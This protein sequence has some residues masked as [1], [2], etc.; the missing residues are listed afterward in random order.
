[1]TSTHDDE[2]TDRRRGGLTMRDIAALAG[3]SSKSV[4]LVVNG[5]PGV[6]EQT[7][8]RIQELI[9]QHGYTPRAQAQ[10]LAT[11][12]AFLIA[13]VFNN[14]NPEY[15]MLMQ[16]GLLDA[17]EETGHALVSFPMQR[18][19][20]QFLDRLRSFV[21]RHRLDGVVFTSSVSEDR[22]IRPLMEDLGVPYVRVAAKALDTRPRSVVGGDRAAAGLAAEHLYAL[23]HR[24]IAMVAG[25]PSFLS[26]RERQSGFLATLEGFG[27]ALAPSL[28]K[29]GEYTFASGLAAGESLLGGPQPPTAVFA[30]N[31][32]MAV[33]V[34]QAAQRAGLRVPNDLTVVG[35]DDFSIATRVFP[36]L[37]TVRI[38]T[39]EMG[40]LAS[41][42]LLQRAQGTSCAPGELIIRETSAPPRS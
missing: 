37:T 31:D 7:R 26:A 29:G 11:G 10:G 35:F 39:R 36:R 14:P 18:D 40:R 12:R 22:R 30:A 13:H 34:M 5:L 6:G 42:K 20:P 27:A 21:D 33:G 24:E 32:E 23:G 25:P 38:P 15:L 3:V 2:R 4:S 8:L 1:M 19:D 9:E 17:L 28:I 16:Q 41:L